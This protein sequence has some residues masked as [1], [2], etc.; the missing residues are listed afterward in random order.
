MTNFNEEKGRGNRY[1]LELRYAY[2]M[3]IEK[4]VILKSIRKKLTKS[5]VHR[6]RQ[7]DAETLFEKMQAIKK[8]APIGAPSI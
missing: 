3:G 4:L 1:S 7:E 2:A 5:T 8:G 6:W